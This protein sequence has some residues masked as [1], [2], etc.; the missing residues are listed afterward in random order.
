MK[1]TNTATSATLALA[2]IATTIFAVASSALA[3]RGGSTLSNG[4]KYTEHC[5]QETRENLPELTEYDTE[6]LTY[7]QQEER[8][9]RDVYAALYEE[10]GLQIFQNISSSE[11]KHAQS[12][13]RALEAYDLDQTEGYGEL[14]ETYDALIAKGMTSLKDALE[15]GVTIEILDIEDLDNTLANTD[16]EYLERIYN[17]LRKGSINHLNA[18][19][20]T[21]Q[22]NGYETE[23]DWEQFISEEELESRER[24]KM[25]RQQG[26]GKGQGNRGG[27]QGR[28]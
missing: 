28:W 10:Y 17:N 6:R 14:Q 13:A 24:G 19:V 27:G 9:A 3:Y 2:L 23:L 4:Q 25:G 26:R 7:G 16:N 18:F 8:L 5:S 15:V 11:E 21:L 1:I 20:R 22:K 12:I